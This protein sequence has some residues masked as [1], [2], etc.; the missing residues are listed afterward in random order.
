MEV[1]YAKKLVSLKNWRCAACAHGREA[2][3]V[4]GSFI[5]RSTEA[6]IFSNK[7]GPKGP[8]GARRL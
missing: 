7:I 3:R 8:S 2:R 6:R 1:F 4:M 5:T